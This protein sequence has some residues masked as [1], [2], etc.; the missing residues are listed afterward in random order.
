MVIDFSTLYGNPKGIEQLFEDMFR[1]GS[2]YRRLPYPQVN[3]FEDDDS[4]RVDISIPG[5]PAKEVELT[6]TA[7]NLI[8]RGERHTPE[9][10]YFR[11]ER[12]AGAF[13]RVLSLNVP[14]D[15]DKV[16]ATSDNGILRVVLPKADA[17]RP[18]KIQISS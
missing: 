6:L 15:R 18:R 16:T 8:I 11:Q 10:R 14:V 17:V 9:G 4:Y 5:V 2:S 3:I 1:F 12:M 13:Q 7:R